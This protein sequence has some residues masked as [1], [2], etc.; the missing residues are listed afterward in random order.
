MTVLEKIPS[1]SLVELV[2]AHPRLPVV[3]LFPGVPQYRAPSFSNRTLRSL[4][5]HHETIRTVQSDTR[6]EERIMVYGSDE[7]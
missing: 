7:D 1:V 5:L 6:N 3:F 4:H 2:P